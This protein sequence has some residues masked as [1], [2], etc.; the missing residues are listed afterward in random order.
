MAVMLKNQLGKKIQLL[1]KQK[2]YTQDAFAEMIG[3]DP[4]NVSRIENGNSYPSPETLIS[5][6]RA[7]EVDVYEL[8]VFQNDISYESMR[9][10]IIDALEQKRNVLYLYRILKGIG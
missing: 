8:F 6:A 3:I 1:R 7:L 5:I 2:K 9:Q 4:K 10:E